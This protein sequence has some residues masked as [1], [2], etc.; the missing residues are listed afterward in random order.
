MIITDNWEQFDIRR[1]GIGHLASR[2]T[3]SD[4]G[5]YFKPET[6]NVRRSALNGSVVVAKLDGPRAHAG[7]VDR[8]V[9]D[10]IEYD[11]TRDHFPVWLIEL[12][13]GLG[14]TVKVRPVPVGPYEKLMKHLQEFDDYQAEQIPD[15]NLEADPKD[16]YDSWDERTAEYRE[17]IHFEVLDLLQTLGL[18][19]TG[20]ETI[21]L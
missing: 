11:I 20:R 14:L 7:G 15:G 17:Y 9:F 16:G 21:K 1:K 6:L 5:I 4:T 2:H 18:R 13:R 10:H 8:T 19:K 12:L 3:M